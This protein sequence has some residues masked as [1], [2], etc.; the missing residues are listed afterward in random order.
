MDLIQTVGSSLGLGLLAGIRLYATVL[1]LGLAVRFQLF[2]LSSG[3]SHLQV[4][5]D[6]RVL[7]VAAV[8]FVCE[9]LADKIPWVDSLWDSLHTFVRP[10]GAIFL[11]ATAMG[12]ADPVMQTMVALLCGGLAFSG[13]SSKAATRFMINHSP[14]PFSNVALSLLEDLMVPAGLWLAFQH[15][16]LTIFAVAIF[17]GL[18]AWFAPRVFRI[19]KLQWAA[20]AAMFQRLFGGAGPNTQRPDLP[21]YLAELKLRDLK[22]TPLGG[23]Y[24]KHYLREKNKIPG[25]ITPLCIRC[26]ATGGIP[27]LHNSLGYLCFGETDLVFLTK[28]L[29]RF[30]THSIPVSQIDSI[31]FRKGILMDRLV[32]QSQGP[33]LRFDV[34]KASAAT[35]PA[36]STP[37]SQFAR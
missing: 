29:L 34:L 33:P 21:S 18:F 19:V 20:L 22:P 28:R 35:A 27:G 32:L 23:E 37:Q 13:H 11:G 3:L 25:A 6:A 5:A 31:D 26:A 24:L 16:L 17:L 36:V 7:T 15:P 10:L 30:R 4:L 8:A 1:A 14:E 2:E 12:G 9:F